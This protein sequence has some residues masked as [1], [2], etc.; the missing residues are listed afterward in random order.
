[1]FTGLEAGNMPR[2]QLI[3][4]VALSSIS[5]IL[6]GSPLFGQAPNGAAKSPL[7]VHEWGTFTSFAGSDGVNL[8]FRPLID[9]DLPAFV[10]SPGS[11]FQLT[12]RSIWARQRMETPVTYFYSD[13]ERDVNVSVGF[14]QG[15]LTE[16]YPPPLTHQS[17]LA[18]DQKTVL[19]ER[20]DW[21]RVHVIPERLLETRIVNPDVA[22]RVNRH[23]SMGLV[24][25]LDE[26]NPYYEAR[27][28]DSALLFVRRR[29]GDG[30]FSMAAGDFHGDHFEKFLFY[31]GA[32]QIDLPLKAVAIDGNRVHLRNLSQQP[33]RGGLVV[34]YDGEQ[35]R[36]TVVKPLKP[37][38]ETEATLP[39]PPVAAQGDQLA[40]LDAQFI[41]Q[42]TA[43]G[44]Y[45]K[46]A[47]SM[48]N[49]WRQSWYREIGLRVF[50]FVPQSQTDEILPLSIDPKPDQLVRVLVA[51]TELMTPTEE[52]DV[53]A[54][55]E[56][57]GED[58]KALEALVERLAPRGRL[59]E[60]AL[61]RCA[62]ISKR[63]D[64]APV[65]ERVL[66]QLTAAK[67]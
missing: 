28:T 2:V 45:E 62:A 4:V 60:A 51:R 29:P 48:V 43:E 21:G 55:L 14:R 53:L 33:I 47:R 22:G 8:E 11:R 57:S 34:H 58:G 7:I 13:I 19:E 63:K 52:R 30:Q 17:T 67:S 38:E 37:G 10:N 42:L 24:P 39:A 9:S 61:K 15:R 41:M 54:L 65:I 1:V 20:V 12:K 56:R 46:E 18:A 16:F 49:T 3:C 31:R 50:F 27:K 32:G 66:P 40:A 59:A 23:V 25:W 35:L 44:L 26:R 36:F 6:N 5:L 64:L